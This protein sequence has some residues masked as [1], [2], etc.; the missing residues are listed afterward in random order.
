[1]ELDS[2]AQNWFCAGL[3]ADKPRYSSQCASVADYQLR[4][5][6]NVQ[7]DNKPVDDLYGVIYPKRVRGTPE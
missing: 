4:D 3:S 2:P 7:N 1:M 5:D 6:N